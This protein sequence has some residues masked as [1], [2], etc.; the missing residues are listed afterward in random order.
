MILAATFKLA[1]SCTNTGLGLPSLYDR[2]C[3]PDG[4]G[5]TIDALSDI[6]IIIA[7]VIRILVAV[8][9]VLAVI[10]IVVGGLFYVTS[11]GDPGRINRAREIIKQAITGL[12]ITLVSYPAITFI[13]S[14][15]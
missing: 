13:A 10:F 11:G 6:W 8:G 2:L 7:N 9:G 5:V 14:K 1:A 3:K 12:V 4:S 15:F